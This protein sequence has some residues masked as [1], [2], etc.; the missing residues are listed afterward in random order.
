[1]RS[2]KVRTHTDTKHRYSSQILVLQKLHSILDLIVASVVTTATELCIRWNHITGVANISSAGQTI[3]LILSIAMLVRVFYVFR[4]YL[5]NGGTNPFT[6]VPESRE[7]DDVDRFVRLSLPMSVPV[8]LP[9]RYR[10]R[11]SQR[12]GRERVLV[13]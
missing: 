2:Y 4:R 7:P 6:T 13:V 3:P 1:M 5:K 10:R 12:R 9:R 8:E 11:H